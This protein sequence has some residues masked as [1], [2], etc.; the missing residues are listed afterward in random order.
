RDGRLY[1]RGAADMKGGVASKIAAAEA[2]QRA[3]APLF[4]SWTL[5]IVA[6]EE[7]G[8]G[9]TRHLVESGI[10]G[11]WAIVAEPTEL[12]PVIAHKGSANLRVQVRGVAAHASTPEHGINAVEQAARLIDRLS[13]LT[14]QLRAREHPL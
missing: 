5:A 1:G 3:E 7:E 12:L 9:G 10:R 14:T 11:T 13:D 8:N 4:G 2:V 6:D